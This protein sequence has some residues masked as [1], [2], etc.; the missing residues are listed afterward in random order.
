LPAP[1]RSSGVAVPFRV[2]PSSGVAG[3][4]GYPFPVQSWRPRKHPTL[5]VFLPLLMPK[6]ATPWAILSWEFSPPTRYFPNS[7]T[8]VSRPTATSLGVSCPFSALGG[9]SPRPD[10][11]PSQAPRFCRGAAS[12]SHPASYGVA[13]RFSQPRSDFFLPPPS[14]HVSDRWRS[15]GLPFRGL[16]LSPRPGQLLAAGM[17]S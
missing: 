9:G 11:L 15:W 6:E 10:R 5:P 17:P 14:C 13:H 2:L 8:E 3:L 4:L 7:P 12:R 16:L 1:H